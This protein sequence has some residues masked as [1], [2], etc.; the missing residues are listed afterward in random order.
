MP[1]F[2]F[3]IPVYNEAEGLPEFYS[4]LTAVVADLNGEA[5]LIFVDDGST[6]G[7]GELLLELQRG[8]RSVR[9]VRLARNFGHQIAITAGLDRADGD[10]T[11]IMDADL[12]DPPE[13][14][15]E[16]A[17]RWEE[18]Y[19]VVYA[20]RKRRHGE[21]WSKRI[22]AALFYKLLGRLAR[23]EIPPN[24]GDYRLVD[25]R[26]LAVFRTL[27]E[28]NRYVRGMFS[29]VGFRQT[30][31]EYERPARYAG[32]PSYSFGTSW[33]L[34]ID[35]LISFSNAPLQLALAFGFAI[36]ILSFV[37][38]VGAM[39]AKLFGAF[40]VPGWTSIVVVV[41]FV[42]GVQLIVLGMLG[43]YVGRIYD[44]VKARPLYTV[45]ETHGFDGR[46]AGE[47]HLA[48]AR[49]DLDSSQ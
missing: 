19:D 34:A 48:S 39:V 46:E 30:G 24:V 29:W 35:G 3:V 45:G 17:A 43:L 26:A 13:L 7:S 18:G 31:V 8:D 16:L 28:R 2:S 33:R 36:S 15:L 21:T 37:V 22:T 6:D 4:R 38:G 5:E 49:R 44:E 42:G 41:S 12:Q 25:R 9:V 23:V 27:R 10:A 20:I 40:V 1:R 14:T 32:E 11:V 47:S